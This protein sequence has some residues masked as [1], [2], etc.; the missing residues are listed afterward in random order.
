MT[1]VP[2]ASVIRWTPGRKGAVLLAVTMNQLTL[3]E[4][5]RRYDLSEAEL[6]EWFAAFKTYGYAGLR[7]TRSQ[8]LRRAKPRP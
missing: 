2:P 4:A 8:K 1:D 5:C 6:A 3:E 7:T